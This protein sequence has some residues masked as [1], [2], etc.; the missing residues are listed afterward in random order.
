MGQCI[1]GCIF[2]KILNT[3]NGT[4][5]KIA[6]GMSGGGG[7][8]GKR[9][10][11]WGHVNLKDPNKFVPEYA[12]KVPDTLTPFG[13]NFI[14]KASAH[15]PPE[16]QFEKPVTTF[17]DVHTLSFIIEFPDEAKAKG[18]F[19]SAAYQALIPVR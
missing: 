13:G 3:E 6:E 19:E 16:M 7:A 11:A 1:F 15:L 4:M 14:G 5:A 10:Y 17:G 8:G 2:A 9:G 18:W 12:M